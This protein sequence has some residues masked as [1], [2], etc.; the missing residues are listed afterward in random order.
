MRSPFN[1]E[2]DRC[3]THVKIIF[4]AVRFFMWTVQKKPKKIPLLFSPIITFE[5]FFTLPNIFFF[6]H[7]ILSLETSLLV[8]KSSVIPEETRYGGQRCGWVPAVREQ[9]SPHEN[10]ILLATFFLYDFE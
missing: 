2:A 9:T 1:N 7:E 5:L 10:Y 4:F 3:I 6:Y 8:L